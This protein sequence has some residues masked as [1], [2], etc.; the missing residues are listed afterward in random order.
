MVVRLELRERDPMLVGYAVTLRF[1]DGDVAMPVR[2][3]DYVATHG[4][5]HMHRYNGR[6]KQKP[7]MV[8]DDSIQA[9]LDHAIAEIRTSGNEMIR[10]WRR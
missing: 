10:A 7:E 3:Y 2:L 1:W 6:K 8:S 5:H 4:V 9:G